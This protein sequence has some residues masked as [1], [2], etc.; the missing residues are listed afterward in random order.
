[1]VTIEPLRQEFNWN[2]N[3]E[4]SADN[5]NAGYTIYYTLDGTEPTTSSKVYTG[6]FFADNQEV[7]AVSV[8]NNQTG[9]VCKEQFGYV[10][11]TGK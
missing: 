5:L 1:M 3:S 10:K 7:S 9:A 8:L 6:P 11:R 2:R 4:N